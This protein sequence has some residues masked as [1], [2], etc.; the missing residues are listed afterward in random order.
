MSAHA[1]KTILFVEDD[2]SDVELTRRAFEELGFGPR[3]EVCPDGRCALA[4]LDKGLQPA[5]ILTDVKMPFVNGL[6]LAQ[7]VRAD[8]RWKG[9]PIV[10]LTSSSEKKDREAAAALGIPDF[11]SKPMQMAD[12]R[13]IVERLSDILDGHGAVT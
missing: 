4:S 2:E 10:F 9:I 1:D 3:L 12:Y 13:P 8:A 11:L 6:E 7:T 5:L